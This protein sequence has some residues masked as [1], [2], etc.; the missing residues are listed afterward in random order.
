MTMNWA[1][2]TQR[3]ETHE[4]FRK[5][6]KGCGQH[7]AC[8]ADQGICVFVGGLELSF[9]H[10]DDQRRRQGSRGPPGV[11]VEEP[12]RAFPL[13]RRRLSPRGSWGNL[14]TPLVHPIG[15]LRLS[16]GST[17][18]YPGPRGRGSTLERGRDIYAQ[19]RCAVELWTRNHSA[20]SLVSSGFPHSASAE[21][22]LPLVF[23]GG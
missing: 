16:L 6:K 8:E 12:S 14:F 19:R 22:S 20:V 23:R 11:G 3:G 4:L 9:A 15:D 2:M 13:R 1:F 7:R 5:A 10:Q 18:N 17:A 21:L